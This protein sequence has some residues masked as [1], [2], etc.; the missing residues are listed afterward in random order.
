V[1]SVLNSYWDIIYNDE[2]IRVTKKTFDERK[3][4]A[5]N[6]KEIRHLIRDE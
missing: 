1:T 4:A 5:E 3:D 6:P 2:D